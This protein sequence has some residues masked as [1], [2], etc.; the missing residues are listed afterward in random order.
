M[1]S[2]EN[3]SK[4]WEER[5]KKYGLAEGMDRIIDILSGLP[6]ETYFELGIGTGWPL[7]SGLI[8]N[9]KDVY[10]CDLSANVVLCAISDHSELYGKVYAG[11]ISEHDRLGVMKYDCTYC[12][13]TSWCMKNFPKEELHRMIEITKPGGYVVFNI[14]SG[15]ST[16][17]KKSVGKK[18]KTII[19]RLLHQINGAIKVIIKDEDYSSNMRNYVVSDRDIVKELSG[20]SYKRI[21]INQLLDENEEYDENTQKI[22]YIVNV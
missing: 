10:G 6:C 4:I 21:S 15:T 7:A 1:S 17:N 19:G 8:E 3:Y 9:G 11:S 20:Y 18:L 2:I 16:H 13:R 5:V 14:I 12:I 22:L